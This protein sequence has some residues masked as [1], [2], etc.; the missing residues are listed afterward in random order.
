[1]GR[2]AHSLSVA[3][4]SWLP[5][6]EPAG[7]ESAHLDLGQMLIGSVAASPPSAPT[8]VAVAAAVTT[9]AA[10][11]QANDPTSS[12][13][14]VAAEVIQSQA[15]DDLQD[16]TIAPPGDEEPAE[17]LKAWP[18]FDFNKFAPQS[19]TNERIEA[20]IRA[21]ELLKQLQA[22]QQQPT[23]EQR[24][25]LLRYIGW[26]GLARVF[27][28]NN[29]SL[30]QYQKQ[31]ESLLTEEEFASARAST[32]NAHYTDP[33]VVKAMWDMVRRLGFKGGR[34]IEPAG[35]TGLFLAGMPVEFA[36]RSEI[37]AVELDKIS[38][39]ILDT[40]FSDLGVQTHIAGIEKADVPHG[41]YDLAI[42]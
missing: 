28:P 15:L 23:D 2:K 4:T 8:A 38:G 16:P 32:P 1:M 3:A 37:T 29:G 30:E 41:F 21:V 12:A 10:F 34:V 35:G 39:A 7:F 31:L 27:E 20:N 36:Q 19:G 9:F 22:Q 5:G 42:W 18:T 11:G 40:V 13:A 14:Q 17:P 33:V 24:H 6:F 26:G 25:E